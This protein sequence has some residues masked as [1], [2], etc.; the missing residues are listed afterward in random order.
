MSSRWTK[1]AA[2][3]LLACFALPAQQPI[4]FQY[5]YDDL[6]Q[7]A[8][9]VD[10]TGVVIQYV[11]DP[12]GNIQQIVR[13]SVAAGALTIFN[14]TP[15]TAPTGGT[16]TIQ[17]QGFSTTPSA[18]VVTINGV[19]ATVLS[20]S[21]T[22]LVVAVPAN[23]TSGTL[24]V[25]VRGTTVTSSGPVTIVPLPILSSVSPK[26]ALAGTSLS[27]TATGANLTGSSFAF[28][29]S[30]NAALSAVS[31]A[32]GGTSVTMTVTLAAAA[33]GRYTL[34]ATNSAGS[35]DPTPKV[36][37]LDTGAAAF[38]TLTVPGPNPN[39]DP[40]GDGLTNAQEIMLGTDPLNA[41]TDGDGYQDG[42]E[43][44]LGSDPRN[45]ASIPNI[46]PV[47]SFVGP[48]L[49]ALNGFSPAP[50][51]PTSHEQDSLLSSVLNG[52][53]PAPSGPTLH[54]QDGLLVSVLNAFSPAPSGPTTQVFTGPLLSVL[55]GNSP[56]PVG[57]TLM[58][59]DG[60]L[61]SILNG[62]SQGQFRSENSGAMI[63]GVPARLNAAFVKEALLRGS[64][65]INGA[66]VC[67]D[68][69]GDGLCDDDE[70]LLGTDSFNP[71]TDGDGYPDG[72]ELALGS[73]PLNPAN[74][75]NINPSGYFLTPAIGI[76]NQNRFA[77]LNPA[78]KEHYM[79]KKQ[80]SR[81]AIWQAKLAVSIC[82]L[83]SN[84]FAQSAKPC[85]P[86]PVTAMR[87]AF[88]NTSLVIR[89]VC[90]TI[91]WP[92]SL[93][94]PTRVYSMAFQRAVPPILRRSIAA[95]A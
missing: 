53:S 52:F 31:I 85:R 41:D 82:C 12:V 18:N 32:S 24:T 5:F 2:A 46:N 61:F 67:R 3:L 33:Q 71:D 50:T 29:P 73:D 39:A 77:E 57:P 74:V 68:S 66:P 70:L 7:L 92:W 75:P 63:D 26:S 48:L 20:A 15:Q 30:S 34:I 80:N 91:N 93:L 56:L 94:R 83:A 14:F 51:N 11:Y 6:N 45:P 10:S 23:A 87:A 59:Q 49:S 27:F 69:D 72:L 47:G 19:A 44:A 21:A 89:R 54:E 22:T 55:N 37:F 36:W 40:D 1:S 35:S 42:L 8:K 79:L 13:S 86:K 90:R 60:L 64:Q 25:T 95:P 16:I 43:V 84:P 17:G 81:S 28:S 78:S 62:M 9:V 58:E 65:F 88:P 76:Q 38:N 4:S